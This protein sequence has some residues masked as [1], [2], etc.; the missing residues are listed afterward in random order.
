M[1]SAEDIKS[2]L[3]SLTGSQRRACKKV[4]EGIF[5]WK[6]NPLNLGSSSYGG[7]VWVV[8][9]RETTLADVVRPRGEW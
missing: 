9:A 7:I 8:D 1:Q 5:W 6:T 3:D 4:G 2:D